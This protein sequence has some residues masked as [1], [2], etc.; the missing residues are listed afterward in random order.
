MTNK[1]HFENARCS[2][3]NRHKRKFLEAFVEVVRYKG[4]FLWQWTAN[5]PV[6]I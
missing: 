6:L 3:A 2:A 4:R 1:S 5:T